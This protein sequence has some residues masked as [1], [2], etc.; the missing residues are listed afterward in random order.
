MLDLMKKLQLP[1]LLVAQSGLGTINHTLLSLDMLKKHCL[2]VL[3]V[4]MNGPLNPEN[5]KAIEHFGNTA[6]CAEIEPLERIDGAVLKN[7]FSRCFG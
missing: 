7:V 6:V 4:V 3:G 1:V 5:R 2:Q